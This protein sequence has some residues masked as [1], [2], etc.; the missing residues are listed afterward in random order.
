VTPSFWRLLFGLALV[1]SLSFE[2]IGEK[3]PVQNVWD[4]PLFF[5]VAGALGCLL[6]IVLAKGVVSPSIDRAED[7]YSEEDAE[8]DWS[9][10]SPAAAEAAGRS[11]PAGGEG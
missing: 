11:F 8:G 3:P 4:Y 2:I 9:R 5:A 1:G 6:L 10:E 7:F